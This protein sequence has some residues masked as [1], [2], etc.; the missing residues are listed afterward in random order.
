MRGFVSQLRGVSNGWYQTVQGTGRVTSDKLRYS[1]SAYHTGILRRGFATAAAGMSSPKLS[2][3]SDEAKVNRELS[4]LLQAQ[5]PW[6]LCANGQGV[7]R[8]FQ[9][10]TFKAAWVS[11]CRTVRYSSWSP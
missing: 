11:E 1:H 3:G 10:K 6:E 8:A 7:E 4:T 5:H 9:F 2:Q